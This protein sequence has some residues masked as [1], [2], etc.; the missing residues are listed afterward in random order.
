MT[1]A[2]WPNQG[3]E[4]ISAVLGSYARGCARHQGLQGRRFSRTQATARIAGAGAK[5]IMLHGYW[6]WDWADQRLKVASIDVGKR[7]ITLQ[8]EPQHALGFRPGQWYYAYNL[9]EGNRPAR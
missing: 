4:K 8:A 9:L 3:F 2:R 6:F 7:V 5:D 1:L